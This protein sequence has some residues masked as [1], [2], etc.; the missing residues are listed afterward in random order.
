MPCGRAD[1]SGLKEGSF[2]AGTQTSEEGAQRGCCYLRSLKENFLDLELTPLRK[3]GAWLCWFLWGGQRASLEVMTGSGDHSR[4]SCGVR[5]IAGG[6]LRKK[7]APSPLT[8][9]SALLLCPLLTPEAEIQ[10][11][12]S[13]G[14]YRNPVP[15]TNRHVH[16]VD[17]ELRGFP[18]GSGGKKKNLPAMQE[19][20]V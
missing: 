5:V 14:S 6:T 12:G 8:L 10:L 1:T 9:C 13:S 19:T 18:G 4:P 11:T 2:R 7:P 17:L 3:S 20:Q 16:R 15:L